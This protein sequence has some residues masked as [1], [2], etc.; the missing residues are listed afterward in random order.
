MKMTI[1]TA[2][3]TLGCTLTVTPQMVFTSQVDC[4]DYDLNTIGYAVCRFLRSDERARSKYVTMSYRMRFAKGKDRRAKRCCFFVPAKLLDLP[5][6][7]AR[8]V[9][10]VDPNGVTVERVSLYETYRAV[11]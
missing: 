3:S 2:Y 7:T 5:G 8:V 6:E 10:S 11:S 4:G 9:L 1:G